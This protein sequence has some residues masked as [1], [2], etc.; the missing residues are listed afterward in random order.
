MRDARELPRDGKIAGGVAGGYSLMGGRVNVKLL[1]PSELKLM[2]LA[3]L[4][5]YRKLIINM[6]IET[7]ISLHKQVIVRLD[8]QL[9]G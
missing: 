2:C 1:F 5:S 6:A 9:A 8:Y 7:S 4:A 3:D